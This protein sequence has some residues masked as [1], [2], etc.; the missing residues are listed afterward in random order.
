M[1]YI[2]KA[3]KLKRR[4]IN[5]KQMTGNKVEETQK[6]DIEAII[7]DNDIEKTEKNPRKKK[8]R[9]WDSACKQNTKTRQLCK[10]HCRGGYNIETE[11]DF[12]KHWG[13][14]VTRKDKEVVEIAV[15]VL[16]L[17]EKISLS[18]SHTQ[19]PEHRPRKP[20]SQRT[21]LTLKYWTLRR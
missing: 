14:A 7:L 10:E 13:A 3:R 1:Q 6:E 15:E 12:R 20:G 19:C 21:L 17:M 9:K 4:Y 2:L 11:K 5:I 18:P 8:N 16:N